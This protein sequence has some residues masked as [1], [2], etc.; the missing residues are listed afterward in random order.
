MVNGIDFNRNNLDKSS[1]PYLLQHVTNPVWWQEWNE[2]V[3]DYGKKS[4][5]SFLVSIGYSTC[6][7]CHVMAEDTFSDKDTACFLNE[8]FVCIKVDRE[9]RPDIDQVMMN[10]IQR[11]TGSGGWPLNVFLNSSLNPVYALTYAPSQQTSSMYSFL[12]IAGKVLEF[13]RTNPDKIPEFSPEYSGAQ[14]VSEN[15]IIRMLS[16]YY[17]AANGGFGHSQKF[18]PHSTLLFLIYQ[19]SVQE[20]PSINTIVTKTLDAIALKGLHDHLQGGIFRYCVDQEWTIPHFEKMLY[21]QA[22]ALWVY[23]AAYKVLGRGLYKNMAL[24]I[25]KC[26]DETF[27]RDGL[28]ITGHDAD[29]GHREGLTYL[30][31]YDQIEESLTKDEFNRFK[32]VYFITPQGNFEQRNHFIRRNEADIGYIE[33]KLLAVRKLRQQPDEDGKI[34]SGLNGLLATAMIQCARC[35]DMPSLEDKA[36]VLVSK[37]K[38]KFWN[39]GQLGH[40]SYLDKIQ[41]QAFLFDAASLLHATSL[42]CE[43]DN[44]MYPFMDELATYLKTFLIDGKW[45]ESRSSDFQAVFASWFDHPVPSSGS[46]AESALTRYSILKG[47]E[48][49][50]YEYHQPFESDFYNVNAMIRNGLFHIY[51]SK[52]KLEWSRLPVNSIQLRGIHEQDCYMGV[53]RPLYQDA[54]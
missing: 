33:E 27:E 37:I 40:S 36:S 6:H 5:K 13:I 46:L 54:L 52:D 47:E 11:Q 50:Q 26:L 38:E 22:L 43:S 51:T 31:S 39:N 4:G 24:K 28:F 41:F 8:N 25:L 34:M 42:L 23:S 20:S 18:P 16:D 7:W 1:S 10:F 49:D 9:Q 45:L 32:E 29:T 17:D 53:C 19:L 2:E 35:L 21:D 12:D 15:R 30:W 48:Y 44:R 14:A 3:I